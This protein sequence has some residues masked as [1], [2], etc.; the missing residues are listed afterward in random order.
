MARPG[1]EGQFPGLPGCLIKLLS[2]LWGYHIVGLAM[3][4][5]QGP[6]GDEADPALGTDLL[7]SMRLLIHGRGVG[8]VPD[9]AYVS[10]ML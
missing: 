3:D 1:Q 6:G 8:G 5:E 4:D 10:G 2:L 7:E 9:N